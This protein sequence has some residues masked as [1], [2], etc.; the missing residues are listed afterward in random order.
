MDMRRSQ[1]NARES[2]LL[3]AAALA[4][5]AKSG[6][7]T[8]DGLCSPP[9]TPTPWRRSWSSTRT[10]M[11][12]SMIGPAHACLQGKRCQV[13]MASRSGQSIGSIRKDT[14]PIVHVTLPSS[15]V[16]AKGWKASTHPLQNSHVLGF[17]AM[18]T[19]S[20]LWGQQCKG[21]IF[22][23]MGAG[24]PAWWVAKTC[25]T[26]ISTLRRRS[27]ARP[28]ALWRSLPAGRTNAVRKPWESSVPLLV[29][30][31]ARHRHLLLRHLRA[32]VLLQDPEWH[33]NCLVTNFVRA[34]SYIWMICHSCTIEG[35]FALLHLRPHMIQCTPQINVSLQ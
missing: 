21:S 27:F 2:L 12:W 24:T 15:L 17:V 9:L 28:L 5:T 8:T 34:H 32:N 11:Q 26:W 14:L 19:H 35:L 6:T 4:K 25:G 10:S 18:L 7:S 31:N 16:S 1:I 29:P 30:W 22:W 23:H 20:I 33:L 3:R 13:C